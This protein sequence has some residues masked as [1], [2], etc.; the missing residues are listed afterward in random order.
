MARRIFALTLALALALC[1]AASAEVVENPNFVFDDLPLTEEPIEAS[2]VIA[3]HYNSGE[4]EDVWFWKFAEEFMGIRFQVELT[5]DAALYKQLSFA[6]GTMP[7]LYLDMNL[8]STEIMTYGAS[9]G[10]LLAV[11]E[12]ITPEYMPNLYALLEEHPEWRSLITAADGHIYTFPRLAYEPDWSFAEGRYYLNSRWLEEMGLEMPETLDA[13][14]EALYAFKALDENNVPVGGADQAYNFEGYLLNAL[15][16][17]ARG[18]FSVGL[19]DGEVVFP[20]G[21]RERFGEFVTLMNQFYEDG[22]LSPDY[23]TLDSTTVSS[24]IAEDRTLLIAQAPYVFVPNTYKEWACVTPLTSE[25]NDTKQWLP[26]SNYILL[27]ALAISSNC[28]EEKLPALLKFVD[29]FY[30]EETYAFGGMGP[31]TSQKD[32]QMGMV[33]GWYMTEDRYTHYP[34]VDAGTS[35]FASEYDYQMGLIKGWFD[36]WGLQSMGGSQ[37]LAGYENIGKQYNLEDGDDFYRYSVMQSLVPYVV[38][39]FP[40]IVFFTPEQSE[41]IIDLKTTLEN[42]AKEQVAAFVTGS[43]PLEELEDYFDELDGMGYQDYLQYYVDYYANYT[44]E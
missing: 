34:D 39:G 14:I 7:D 41:E 27:G 35:G 16:Y 18:Q 2:V 1:C 37:L 13:L 36:G 38:E 29:W 33:S 10:Q 12:Y 40:D 3:R 44:A 8:S 11:D 30:T 5:D 25:W 4:P 32:Y 23:Y 31:L 43:R 17:L 9:E 42:Y 24:L 6:A 19:R 22:I 21:D 28:A 15:G 26:S 20:F